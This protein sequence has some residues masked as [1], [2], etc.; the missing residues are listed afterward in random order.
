MLPAEKCKVLLNA[1]RLAVRILEL[2]DEAEFGIMPE[3]RLEAALDVLTVGVA[4]S[5]GSEEAMVCQR[6]HHVLNR[7]VTDIEVR[8]LYDKLG[9]KAWRPA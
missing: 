9:L 6:T 8:I 1:T 7:A 2:N 4:R 3:S 5:E